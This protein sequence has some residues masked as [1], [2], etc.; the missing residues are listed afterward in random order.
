M[1]SG[2]GPARSLQ[3][4]TGRAQT[5]EPS[6]A[7][8]A[9]RGTPAAVARVL[10][11]WGAAEG[12]PNPA[13]SDCGAREPQDPQIPDLTSRRR[14]RCPGRPHLPLPRGQGAGPRAG[15]GVRPAP[16]A[17][18]AP[19]RG[20][21]RPRRS[22]SPRLF[23]R[24]A[25]SLRP[26]R[27]AVV[28]GPGVKLHV[29]ICLSLADPDCLS[30]FSARKGDGPARGEGRQPGV[31]AQAR[32]GPD[33]RR[34][35]GGAFSFPRLLPAPDPV[36]PQTQDTGHSSAAGRGKVALTAHYSPWVS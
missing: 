1:A 11:P 20:P 13:R 18:R 33:P 14:R 6:R 15:S 29:P 3:E 10:P 24:R 9:S 32:G 30:P 27:V 25:P 21:A 36:P 8:F 22:G 12:P 17:R 4:E 7:L 31:G 16:A 28:R 2:P 5:L 35:R 23:P 26:S 34:E 19:A